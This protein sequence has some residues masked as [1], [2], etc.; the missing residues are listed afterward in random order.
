MYKQESKNSFPK[1]KIPVAS[2]LIV[3]TIDGF[4][5]QEVFSGADPKIIISEKFTPDTSTTKRLVG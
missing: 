1:R 2:N 4:R 3:I 5:W